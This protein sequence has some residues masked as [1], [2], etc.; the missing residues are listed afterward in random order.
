[1]NTY[2]ASKFLIIS[3]RFLASHAAKENT[4]SDQ[5]DNFMSAGFLWCH[6]ITTLSLIVTEISIT[7][8]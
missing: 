3:G 4:N 1:M 5:K 2:M 6:R 8:F 7:N